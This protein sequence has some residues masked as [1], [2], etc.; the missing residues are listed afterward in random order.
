M[1]GTKHRFFPLVSE[2]DEVKLY[3]ASARTLRRNVNATAQLHSSGLSFHWS[4][5]GDLE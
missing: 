2:L 1:K 5:V 3:C 4:L